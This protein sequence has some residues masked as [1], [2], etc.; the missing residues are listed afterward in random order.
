[1]SSSRRGIYV[2]YFRWLP[3][4]SVK[5]ILLFFFVGLA[6]LEVGF[7]IAAPQYSRIAVSAL[8]GSRAILQQ[9]IASDERKIIGVGDSTLLGGGVYDHQDIVMG[10]LSQALDDP[11]RSFNLALPGGDTVSSTV[12]LDAM[13]KANVAK[14][15]RVIIEVLPSKFLVS[16]TGQKTSAYAASGTIYELQ[17]F[18]PFIDPQKFGLD[19][20]ALP[21][22]EA[23]EAKAQWRLGNLSMMYRHRDFLRIEYIG[24]Y[25][26]FW[27]VSAL[28][29]R[30]ILMRLFPERGKGTNRLAARMDDFPYERAYAEDT[31]GN[32]PVFTPHVQGDYLEQAIAIAKRISAKPPIIFSFPI[33]YEYDR[34]TQQEREGYLQ[35]LQELKAYLETV[36][37]HTGS[38]L[39]FVPSREFQNP[40]LWTR[41]R[42]HFNA[43][44]HQK[45]WQMFQSEFCRLYP[46]TCRE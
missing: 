43:K 6:L 20:A 26:A 3:R 40:D 22:T 42:A 39:M 27:T 19:I 33:H 25:P 31:N 29:P 32:P 28:I 4:V 37:S 9:A 46:V 11:W 44:G 7:R 34:I 21:R 14:I 13:E 17:R 16:E 41:T 15:D 38:E 23:V 45:I 18:V 30:S 36:A 8:H 2:S 10:K 35:A 5:R 12:M 1:M 24:N